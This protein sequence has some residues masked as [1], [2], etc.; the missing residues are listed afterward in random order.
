MKNRWTKSAASLLL[1]ASILAGN[2]TL[3]APNVYAAPQPEDTQP[4]TKT[5]QPAAQP[6]DVRNVA[7][8]AENSIVSSQ[9]EVL[10]DPAFPRVIEYRMNGK[11]M[12]GQSEP[13]S[14]VKINETEYT[15][16]VTS[17]R[18]DDSTMHYR[19]EFP[20]ISAVI[21]ADLKVEDNVLTFQV[22]KVEENGELVRRIEIPGQNLVSIRTTQPGAFETGVDV[23]GGV[24]YSDTSPEERNALADKAPDANPVEK[25]YLFLNTDELAASITSNAINTYAWGAEGNARNISYQNEK[26]IVYQTVD[27]G[28]YKEMGA[29]SYPW[30]W[31]E[32]DTETLDL[33]MAKVAIVEDVNGSGNVD[34][35]DAAI[36][37]RDIIR[38]PYMSEESTQS[39]FHIAYS[40]ASLAQWPFTK[41]L[42]MVKKLYL[43]TDGFGQFLQLKGYQAEGHDSNHPDYGDSFS[44]KLGGVE[45][46]NLLVDEALEKYN[47]H[48]G[49][50]LNHTEAY[51]EAKNYSYDLVTSTNGWDSLDLSK[52]IDR[53]KDAA[54]DGV[55]G[56]AYR[57]NQLKEA[58]PN[59]QWIYYDVYEAQGY[60]EWKL[61]EATMSE[62]AE[63]NGMAIGTEFQGALEAYSI[64]NHVQCNASPALRI[65]KYGMTDQFFYDPILLE[66]RHAGSM[67]YGDDGNQDQGTGGQTI[68][69][70]IDMFYQN[71]LLFKYMQNHNIDQTRLFEGDDRAF[72]EVRF[73]DG[74][75]G[76][77]I[78]QRGVQK[79]GID[80]TRNPVVELAEDGRL[81]ARY[82]KEFI[83]EDPTEGNSGSKNIT[84]LLTQYLLP[85]DTELD[86]PVSKNG[87]KL[88]HY[89]SEGGATRWEL[90]ASWNNETQVHLYQLTD[91]GRV[92][93]GML[94]V[95]DGFITID[96]EANIPYIVCREND[97]TNIATV[98]EM[99]FGEGTLIQDPGFDY[100]DFRAWD[101]SDEN[102]AQIL[103]GTSGETFVELTGANAAT[104]SQKITGLVPGTTYQLSAWVEVNG[105]TADLVVENGGETFQNTMKVSEIYNQYYNSL[106]YNDEGNMMQRLKLEF[107]AT[108]P[109]ATISIRANAGGEGSY[110]D[111]DDFRLIEKK[112]TEWA[113]QAP[114]DALFFCDFEMAN[115]EGWGPFVPVQNVNRAHLSETHLG[116]TNDTI[117]GKYSFKIRDSVGGYNHGEAVRTISSN[118]PLE[119]G[120]TYTIQFDYW[121]K[122]E[123]AYDVSVSAGYV[124]GHQTVEGG[125]KNNLFAQTLDY[126]QT[127]FSQTF[128][129]PDDGREYGLSFFK[130]LPG[131]EELII[132]N[133]ALYE[134]EKALPELPAPTYTFDTPDDRG[135]WTTAYGTGTA[136]VKTDETGDGY[137]EVTPD[138]EMN[139]M[140]D[141][142]TNDIADGSI[143][144]DITADQNYSAGAVIRYI[145][146]DNYFAVRFMGEST[147]W[148]WFSVVDGEETTGIINMPGTVLQAG[149]DQHVELSFEGE[150]IRMVVD[151]VP[152]FDAEIEGIRTEAGRVGVCGSNKIPFRIDNVL[153]T[154][155]QAET[156]TPIIPEGG[157]NEST[158][159]H[160]VGTTW[161][162]AYVRGGSYSSQNF[163]VEGTMPVKN[164][165]GPSST[166]WRQAYLKFTLPETIGEAVTSAKARLYLSSIGTVVGTENVY[167]V[168]NDWDESTITANNAPALGEVVATFEPLSAQDGYVEIDLTAAVQQALNAGQQYL[169]V[170]IQ[171]ATQAGGS[172]DISIASFEAAD[173][174]QRPRLT[175]DY[176][177]DA[178]GLA[179]SSSELQVEQG[180]TA[181]L[182]ARLIPANPDAQYT[183]SIEDGTIAS[184]DSSLNRATITGLEL[185]ETVV[186]VT[187]GE[188][189]AQCK[190]TVVESTQP[191]LETYAPLADTYTNGGSLADTVMGDADVL[192]IKDPTADGG[193]YY[194]RRIYMSLPVPESAV[195]GSMVSANLKLY[196]TDLPKTGDEVLQFV[197]TAPW[198]EATLTYNN[199]PEPGAVLAEYS[200]YQDGVEGQYYSFDVTQLM[201]DAAAAGK[202]SLEFAI[203]NKNHT[204]SF[205][206]DAPSS[207]AAANQPVLEVLRERDPKPV[208]KT[209]NLAA[210]TYTNGGTLAETVLNGEKVIK[211]KTPT[212]DG[213]AYYDRRAYISLPVPQEAVDNTM[214]KAVLKLFME[215][216]PELGSEVL[217]FVNTAEPWDP[218]TLTY[219]NQPAIAD[220]L[221]EYSL[222]QD[223]VE[224]QY[225][226]FD[227][228]KLLQDAA[229]AGKQ[230]LDFAIVNKNNTQRFGFDATSSEGTE[231]QRPVLE[232]TVG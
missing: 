99:N 57:L 218:A 62:F 11:V 153:I 120:K 7:R 174:A 77:I 187:S 50:H 194:D 203:I 41:T 121:M 211:L 219:T 39:F 102:A 178:G 209:Y 23:K 70:Q 92:D 228:T 202:E 135:E 52:K 93:K 64:W 134:G 45:D 163:G 117:Q 127:R 220:V 150:R 176:D 86:D 189:T 122:T 54:N 67:G 88:Y 229:A 126:E 201:L 143:S 14:V 103:T 205:G 145:N 65:M 2:L 95:T 108:A 17:S 29:W 175:V 15:P 25:S 148:R 71:N 43:Y 66:S 172:T 162:D 197:E 137:L 27:K 98:D 105:R 49:V 63:N 144:F 149:R 169:S 131:K 223:G 6:Q 18:T 212:T 89:N 217:Q 129:V 55:G 46:L 171:H 133:L 78:T 166:Y 20:E 73:E 33:P 195:D 94:E 199:Q 119:N 3:V 183:W 214:S 109:E 104:V 177:K 79:D 186:T 83:G 4:E 13:L 48:I 76:K 21:E 1:S 22:T 151:G 97:P 32:T 132:D 158:P 42:D 107:T 56:L 185:G 19:M 123:G 30:T 16:T 204:P 207:E 116:Y 180:M 136:Q 165:G 69:D 221:A 130:N 35:Q 9:M 111:F 156:G 191:I 226:E 28:E 142:A 113:Q 101:V 213:G 215:D 72:D 208:V 84:P 159:G 96:A 125:D 80:E 90:P 87:N 12:Y 138:R 68:P 161:D 36:A 31:R 115:D 168:S 59:L 8:T 160:Y 44:D 216:L 118:M 173:K 128:T 181:D 190:V 100:R 51:P 196:M 222:Y 210:D 227:V 114:E 146:K 10:V 112:N 38:V 85:W 5:E 75:I 140:L 124:P 224:G 58:V 188:Y 53:Y 141:A 193:G 139:V 154:G 232:V 81:V 24:I 60:A 164:D 155:Q 231:G 170:A 61:A 152:Q 167:L 74:V 82:Q 40:R 179:L 225:Y 106:R 192:R 147:G 157:D 26:R 182:T 206:F 91:T 47:T 230:T 37:G 184:L 200:L 110:V 34:W 198:D